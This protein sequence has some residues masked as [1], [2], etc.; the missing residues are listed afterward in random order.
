[1]AQSVVEVMEDSKGKAHENLLAN[2]GRSAKVLSQEPFPSPWPHGS[3][4]YPVLFT[5]TVPSMEKS[6]APPP[7]YHFFP[8][9]V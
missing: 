9:K 6:H 3:S 2:G 4:E 7:T 5:L 1:M 8:N